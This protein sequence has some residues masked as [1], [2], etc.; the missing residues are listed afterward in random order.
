MEKTLSSAVYNINYHFVWCPKYRKPILK[1]N[2]AKTLKQLLETICESKNWEVLELNIQPDHIHLF[3]NAPP[4]ENPTGIIKV[5]K[6]VSAL[7]LFKTVPSLK[8]K[9]R[10]GHLWSPSY[11]VGTAGHVSADT[12]AKYIKNQERGDSRNSSTR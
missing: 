7:Q 1:G 12:I 11:Y 5:L 6:G 10:K 3:L 8:T 2:I 4:Y 9:M